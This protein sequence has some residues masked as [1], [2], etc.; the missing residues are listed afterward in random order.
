MSPALKRASR[1]A[2]AHRLAFLS[3]PESMHH[4]DA[5][6]IALQLKLI[7]EAT[8]EA[9]TLAADEKSEHAEMVDAVSARVRATIARRHAAPEP[10]P[11]TAI[12]GGKRETG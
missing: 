3:K 10:T 5:K 4:K 8:P 1:L 7:V 6:S 2:V 12:D 11:L 9:L